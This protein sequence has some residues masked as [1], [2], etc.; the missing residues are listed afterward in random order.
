MSWY[1][2]ALNLLWLLGFVAGEGYAFRGGGLTL[3]MYVWQ[4]SE[5]WGPFEFV[6]GFL[7]GALATHFYWH[8]MPPGAGNVG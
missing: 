7:A 6:L 3:S 2:T 1:W 5:A 8:W 4:M